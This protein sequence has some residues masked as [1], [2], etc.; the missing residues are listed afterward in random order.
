M[1]ALRHSGTVEQDIAV[2]EVAITA[3]GQGKIRQT[4][5]TITFDQI[6]EYVDLLRTGEIVGRAVV[7]F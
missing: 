1:A 2:A 6:N 3:L 7:K 4:I 5:K